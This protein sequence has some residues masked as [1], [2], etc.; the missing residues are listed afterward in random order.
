MGEAGL[1]LK[2]TIQPGKHIRRQPNGNDR[3]L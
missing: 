1:V 3:I 2:H